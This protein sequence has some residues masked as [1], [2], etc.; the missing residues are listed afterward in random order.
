[1]SSLGYSANKRPGTAYAAA[2]AA[3][4]RRQ[5]I[6][7]GV[8]CLLLIAVLAYESPSFLK[9]IRGS[10]PAALST[11][12]IPPTVAPPPS[13]KKA[14][15]ALRRGPAVDPFSA[16]A[17]GIAD[18]GFRD[19]PIPA[20]SHDPFA[21]PSQAGS[22]PAVTVAALPEQIVIGTPGGNRTASHGWIVILASVPTGNGKASATR[23]AAN[24]RQSGLGSVSVLNSSNRRPL[25]GGYWV[26]Y[27]GPFKTLSEVT[28]NANSVHS[29]G[30]ATA[31]IRELIVYS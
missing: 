9:L 4:A 1:M 19:V 7:V 13:A 20:G 11:N 10:K 25:R 26:V 2:A 8:L 6:I 17:P 30:Y 23:F 29:R 5:K 27:T 3:K 15:N 18:V 22:K 24:A 14:L 12:V 28:G 31:Y 16:A 21:A